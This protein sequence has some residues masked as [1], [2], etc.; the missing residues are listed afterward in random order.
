MNKRKIVF[1][2]ICLAL[3]RS[4]EPRTKTSWID[5]NFLSCSEFR[6]PWPESRKQWK[7]PLDTNLSRDSRY[8]ADR[9]KKASVPCLCN[10]VQKTP[11]PIICEVKQWISN[12]IS[13]PTVYIRSNCMGKRLGRG[14]YNTKTSMQ[15]TWHHKQTF[16]PVHSSQRFST[17]V[18]L[19]QTSKM[20][21]MISDEQISFANFDF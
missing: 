12:K 16:L 5:E 3:G 18:S 1:C 17:K 4:I 8:H 6:T 21:V 11:V 19:L 13:F 7:I 14:V 20:L 2:F 10:T 9:R 15:W